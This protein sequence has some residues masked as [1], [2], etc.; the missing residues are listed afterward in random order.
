MWRRWGT[1]QNFCLEFIVELEKQLFK[2]VLKWA[3]KNVRILK[4][5]IFKKTWRYHYFTLVYLK[6]WYYLQFLRYWVWQLKLVIMGHFVAL[7]PPSKH[8]KNQNFEKIQKLMEISSFYPCVQNMRYGSWVTTW[9]TIFLSFWVIWKKCK[10]HLEILSFYK[11][12]PWLKIIWCMVP[13]T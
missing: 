1:P 2:K 11:F 5:C 13:Q 10:K 9:D 8:L 12:V 3:I 7:L 6:S 4:C